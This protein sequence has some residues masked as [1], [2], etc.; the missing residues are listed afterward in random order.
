VPTTP[1]TFTVTKELIFRMYLKVKS[2][3]TV[4]NEI[5][6]PQIEKGTE[7]TSYIKGDISHLNS[8]VWIKTLNK[9]GTV[10]FNALKSNIIDTQL[11]K[12]YQWSGSEWV[13]QEAYIY[14]DG[15]WQQ[16]SFLE[17]N[18]FTIIARATKNSTT[19]TTSNVITNTDGHTTIVIDNVVATGGNYGKNRARLYVDNAV[20]L[21]TTVRSTSAS[22]KEV[23]NAWS[24]SFPI[25]QNGTVYADVYTK[26]DAN[27]DDNTDPISITVNF[28]F[29]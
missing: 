28:H 11:D 29:E 2:G 13:K 1:Y 23:A 19:A 4:N 24:G 17:S 16:F 15:E 14:R 3:T 6:Y 7:A 27:I 22:Y 12:I 18:I 5:C 9:Q 26:R 8:Q 21:D 10:S 25:S 20:V